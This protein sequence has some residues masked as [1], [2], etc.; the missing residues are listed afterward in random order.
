MSADSYCYIYSAMTQSVA[1]LIALIGVFTIFKIQ[2]HRQRIDNNYREL[3]SLTCSPYL[4][5]SP[6]AIDKEVTKFLNSG[7]GIDGPRP[8][9]N[10]VKQLVDIIKEEKDRFNFTRYGGIVIIILSGMLFCYYLTCLNLNYWLY[11]K[12]WRNIPVILGACFALLVIL[13]GV[14]YITHCLRR[15]V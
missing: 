14:Y 1:G 2:I 11:G 5:H 3:A 8:V 15:D 9:H 4:H 6:E 12:S 7:V 10:K 13:L